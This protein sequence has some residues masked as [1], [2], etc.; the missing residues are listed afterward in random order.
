MVAYVLTGLI[1]VFLG[2]FLNV[3]IT[4]LPQGEQ[5][6]AGR[7]HC[8]SCGATLAW[9]DNLPL[10]SYL[11]LQ[12][13]CRGCGAPISWRYPAVELAGGVLALVLW[14][15]FPFDSILLA[16]VPFSLALLALSAIDLEH[17][18]LPDA[19][20]LPGIW[21]GLGLS[22]VLPHISFL[23]SAGGA[24]LGGL[25]FYAIGWS[26]Q[27]LRGRRGLGGGD[28][29]LMAMIGAFLGVSAIPVVI[30]FSAALGSLVGLVV[31]LSQGQW[32]Q[33]QWQSLAIPYGPF[34]SAGALIYLM[35]GENLLH[36]LGGL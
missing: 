16:Y 3:V 33:G 27:K 13:H 36:L 21:L 25:S 26:Y 23:E 17:R 4:R 7:S 28:V 8:P 19:I 10:L 24:G 6:W 20:T 32:R 30:F 35:A 9:Y 14:A 12:G 31:A 29:K 11:R 5:F 1:G 2:S 18:I 34:L 15:N 22:L